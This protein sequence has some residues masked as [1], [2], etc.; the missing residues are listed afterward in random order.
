M[1]KLKILTDR[2]PWIGDKPRAAGEIVEAPD[3]SAD[4]L[5]DQGWAREVKDEK[6]KKVARDADA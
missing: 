5:L 1:I 3:D 2:M 4:W 6:P